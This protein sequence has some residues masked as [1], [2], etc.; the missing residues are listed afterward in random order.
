MRRVRWAAWLA[1]LALA[2][3]HRSEK[4]GGAQQG[5]PGAGRP[6]PVEVMELRP[7]PVHDSGEYLGTLISRHSITLYPQVA[8]YVQ[9]IAAKH[10]RPAVMRLTA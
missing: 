5:G 8:G 9:R 6:L 4:K 2:G 10:S 7:G 3:C 1:A